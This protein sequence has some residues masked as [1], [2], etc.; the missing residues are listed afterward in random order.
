VKIG[1]MYAG[2]RREA[3]QSHRRRSV[4]DE[5]LIGRVTVDLEWAGR[6]GVSAWGEIVNKLGNVGEGRKIACAD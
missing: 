2:T 4:R 3:A 6:R 5:G 1:A